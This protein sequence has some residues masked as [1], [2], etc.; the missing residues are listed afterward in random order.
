MNNFYM[1]LLLIVL[2]AF[3]LISFIGFVILAIK[4][5]LK[6]EEQKKPEYTAKPILTNY[7]YTNYLGLKQFATAHSLSIHT[8]VRL[9]DLIEPNR[10]ITGN[11]KTRFYKISSKH[12]DFVFCD[13]EMKVQLIV[14]LD[15]RSHLRPDRKERDKFVDAALTGAGYKIIH[16]HAADEAGIAAID[17]AINSESPIITENDGK[18]TSFTEWLDSQ[19]L[20]YEEWRKQQDAQKHPG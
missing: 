12:V 20:T 16:I 19:G 15:D 1:F 13:K 14:E 8:K 5:I 18:P 11:W 9:A 17:K 10:E 7:E 3:L 2:P 6:P 4:A